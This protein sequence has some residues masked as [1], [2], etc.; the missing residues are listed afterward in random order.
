M[1]FCKWHG[2]KENILLSWQTKYL[3]IP[4]I[5]LVN[6]RLCYA[7]FQKQ[8]SST[9]TSLFCV[10]GDHTMMIRSQSHQNGNQLQVVCKCLPVAKPHATVTN[11]KAE[12]SKSFV[13]LRNFL[14]LIY[15]KSQSVF[16]YSER[17]LWIPSKFDIRRVI[18]ILYCTFKCGF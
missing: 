9:Y 4:Y 2:Q 7:P 6:I 12:V 5:F 10:F 1:F 13:K 8:Q 18:I 15:S 17:K 11:S 3:L 16:L 14:T